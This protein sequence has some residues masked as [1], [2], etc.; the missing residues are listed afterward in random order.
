MNE[1]DD[2]SGLP[3]L[4][5]DGKYSSNRVAPMSDLIAQQTLKHCTQY[6]NVPEN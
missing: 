2:T 1:H 6:A 3:E 4:S 5:N